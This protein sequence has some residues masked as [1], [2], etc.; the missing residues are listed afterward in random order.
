MRAAVA[1]A[2][3]AKLAGGVG[4]GAEVVGRG[5]EVLARLGLVQRREQLARLVLGARIPAKREQRVG[6]KGHVVVE[7]DAA[8]DV[9]DVRVQPAVLVHDQHR[10]QLARRLGRPHEIPA[11]LLVALR[12]L[13]TR[14]TT[15]SAAR[16]LW[17]PAALRR[18][19]GS[20]R[21]APS[22]RSCRPRRTCGPCPGSHGGRARRGRRRQTGSAVR[23][24]NQPR[25]S[26]ST[27][28]L[29]S[30]LQA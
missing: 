4:T 25:S 26:S 12:R 3:G 10:R 22:R 1:E 20:A 23:D 14:R 13:G 17:A 16:R 27:L 30:I 15:P 19:S 11:H 2:D 7:R 21:R 8:R 6:R 24:R 29:V 18:T 5:D 28:R 9:L